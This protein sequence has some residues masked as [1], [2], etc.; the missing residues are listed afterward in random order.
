MA[1][2]RLSKK[3]VLA[4]LEEARIK[5]EAQLIGEKIGEKEGIKKGRKEEKLEMAKKL[6]EKG[7]DLTLI[8]ETS[9]LS[10]KEIEKL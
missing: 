10:I 4:F 1:Q 8:S 5:K 3:F 7:I 9:G 6:K 2:L